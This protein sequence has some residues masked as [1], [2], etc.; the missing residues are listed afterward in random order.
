VVVQVERVDS[1]RG[2]VDLSPV[3]LTLS[4]PDGS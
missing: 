3:E 4:A 2:R 1:A